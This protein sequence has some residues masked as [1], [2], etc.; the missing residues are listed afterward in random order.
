MATF[1]AEACF[2]RLWKDQGVKHI[3]SWNL[4]VSKEL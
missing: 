2:S 1:N 4:N 3:L